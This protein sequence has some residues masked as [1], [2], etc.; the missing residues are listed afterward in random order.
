MDNKEINSKDTDKNRQEV[1][2]NNHFSFSIN[3]GDALSLL[4]LIAGFFLIK[5]V[6]KQRRKWFNIHLT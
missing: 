6:S 4:A 2:V 5:R 1:T 3:F